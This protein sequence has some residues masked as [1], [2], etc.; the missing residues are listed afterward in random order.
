M[1]AMRTQ[2]VCHFKSEES[3]VLVRAGPRMAEAARLMAKCL[4]DKAVDQPKGKP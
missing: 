3:D 2:R 1:R 4:I